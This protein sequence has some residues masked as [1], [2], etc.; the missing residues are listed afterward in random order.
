MEVYLE[1]LRSVYD[2]VSTGQ[3]VAMSVGMYGVYLFSSTTGCPKT[4]FAAALALMGG[5]LYGLAAAQIAT[6]AVGMFGVYILSSAKF[7]TKTSFAVA[8]ALLGGTL[9]GL[10]VANE[11]T[12]MSVLAIASAYGLYAK[13]QFNSW[14]THFAAVRVERSKNTSESNKLMPDI[15]GLERNKKRILDNARL[16]KI[17]DDCDLLHQ[18]DEIGRVRKENDEFRKRAARLNTLT[19]AGVKKMLAGGNITSA[20]RSTLTK[21]MF[22]RNTLSSDL[23]NDAG[24]GSLSVEKAKS[25][26]MDHIHVRFSDFLWA[27]TFIGPFSLVLWSR[28]TVVLKFRKW[29]QKKG[30][31]DPVSKCDYEALAATLC[32][33]QTQ[34][35]HY[36]AKKQDGDQ[37]IAAF[38]FADFP[39]VDNDC[40]FQIANLF[41]VD[42]DLNTK[43]FVRARLDDEELTANE[44][45]T[46]LWYNTIAA[47][48]VKLHAMANWGVNLDD[49]LEELNPFLR[50]NSVCTVMYNY[51]GYT[52]FT[53]FVNFWHRQGLLSKGWTSP[54]SPWVQT[55]DRGIKDNI[56]QHGQIEDLTKHSRFIKFVIRVR[57]IFLKEFQKHK[58]SFPGVNGEAM[59]VGTVLHSLDHTLMDWNLKDPLY[60]DTENNRFGK[61]A[62]MG[63]IVKTGFVSD[64]DGLYFNKRFKGSSHPFYKSVYEKA[65]KIDKQLADHMDTCIIK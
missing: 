34:A 28:K 52:S 60:L 6:M 30:L 56:W 49:S 22:R 24:G 33:E 15:L 31:I 38:F 4:S 37:N 65:A 45:V 54:N 43:R 13:Y 20:E 57:S 8:L 27:L 36:Y 53:T 21:R 23:V 18:V 35:I 64:V 48:H 55:V 63:Q 7:C 29:L 59:F 10:V 41:A 1:H 47:Q 17:F 11:A 58:A 44:A 19:P 5:M 40:K 2:E 16:H 61:M 39:F 12:V 14:E 9:Y 32:L 42:I 46:L 50:H 25:L 3:F 26:N 51:F 62:E